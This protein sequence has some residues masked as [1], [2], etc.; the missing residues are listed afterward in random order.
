MNPA[1]SAPSISPRLPPPTMYFPGD[2]FETSTVNFEPLQERRREVRYPTYEEVQV[3]LLET[4]GIEV[5]GLL[6]DVSRSGF[7]VELCLP[8]RAGARVKVSIGNKVVIFATAR[9]CRGE[10]GTFQVGASIE[11]M[12]CPSALLAARH[13]GPNSKD[14]SDSANRGLFAGEDRDL[15]RAILQEQKLFRCSTSVSDRTV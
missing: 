11:A 6:R 9:Y 3:S 14:G 13:A 2:A 12:F 15:A 4:S 5:S 1:W 7:R 8:V 10:K